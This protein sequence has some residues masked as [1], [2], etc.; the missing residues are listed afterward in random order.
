VV[1]PE[2]A[3]EQKSDNKQLPYPMLHWFLKFYWKLI[4]W[5][6]AGNFPYQYK[7]MVLAVAPHTSWIDVMIGFAARNELKIPHARFLGKKELFVGPLGWLLRK[8]GGTAVD[9]HSKQGMVDQAVA[10]FDNNENFLLGLAP[11]GTRK[12]VDKLRSGFYHIAKKAQVPIL[13]VGLDFKN[14]QLVVG[15]PLFTTDDEAGDLEKIIAFFSIIEGRCPQ[16][17]LQ[18]LKNL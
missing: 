1:H 10:L 18:H 4:G 8:L 6:I 7:K 9:R 5:K 13:P 17:D 15:E 11:E 16:Y 12:R 14:K 2:L 3:L